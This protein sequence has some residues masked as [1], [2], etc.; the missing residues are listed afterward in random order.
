MR[1]IKSNLSYM[2]LMSLISLSPNKLLAENLAT[3]AIFAPTSFWYTPIPI[4]APLHANS[5]RFV[6]DFLRQKTAYYGLL[7]LT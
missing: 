1:I 3:D 5:A 4:N 6:A 7:A 2:M